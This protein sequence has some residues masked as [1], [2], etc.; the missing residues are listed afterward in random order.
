[1]NGDP[2]LANRTYPHPNPS[3]LWNVRLGEAVPLARPWP[4]RGGPAAMRCGHVIIRLPGGMMC[5]T[6][7]HIAV[8]ISLVVLLP[9]LLAAGQNG[10]AG[11]W[12]GEFET[13]RHR[14]L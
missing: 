9:G 6:P 2:G 4:T 5:R 7:V 8:A 13:P 12:E 14:S 3:G 1:M 11:S 10:P